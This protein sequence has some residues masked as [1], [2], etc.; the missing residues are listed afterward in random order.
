[1]LPRY[2]KNC[3]I[4]NQKGPIINPP[5]F[6][7]SMTGVPAHIVAVEKKFGL[8]WGMKSYPCEHLGIMNTDSGNSVQYRF[9][10]LGS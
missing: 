6:H 1:M 5:E 10:K 2:Q 4:R 3:F 9:W 7:K 8:I